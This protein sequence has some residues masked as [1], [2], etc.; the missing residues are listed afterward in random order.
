MKLKKSL[1]LFTLFLQLASLPS[2]ASFIIEFSNTDFVIN[3]NVNRLRDFDFRLEVADDLVAG[4]LYE[5]PPITSV[6][7]SIFGILDTDP[8]PSE[9][10]AF[11]LQRGPLLNAEFYGQGSSFDIEIM[12]G[13]DLT[14]GIQLAELTTFVFN[15][16]V[17]NTGRY[18][19][20]L[21][22]LFSDGTGSIQ[23]SNNTGGVNPGN[24]LV[25]DVD[26]AEEY[27]VDLTA[28]TS[29]TISTPAAIPEPSV[30]FLIV[31]GASASL[32]RRK[33]ARS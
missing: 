32:M 21:I 10:P 17:I 8:T 31:I 9:F 16:R 28:S 25:V 19:P 14:D 22:Q 13:A 7:Y 23:N 4:L 33:R 18:H 3:P 2:S 20:T 1:I 12:A 26:F 30:S 6:Q 15:G 27:H 29:L 11:D 24:G 5:D